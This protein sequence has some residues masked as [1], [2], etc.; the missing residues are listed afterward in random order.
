MVILSVDST[1][2][3]SEET[4]RSEQENVYGTVDGD[5]VVVIR[6]LERGHKLS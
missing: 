2:M 6:V 3:F 4:E 5:G 1:T